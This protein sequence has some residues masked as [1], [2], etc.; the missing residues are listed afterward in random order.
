MVILNM[1]LRLAEVH[2]VTVKEESENEKKCFI[3]HV[4]LWLARL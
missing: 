2:S 3:E 4:S 1:R